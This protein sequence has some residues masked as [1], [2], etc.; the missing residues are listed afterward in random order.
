MFCCSVAAVSCFFISSFHLYVGYFCLVCDCHAGK[1]CQP[2][3]ASSHPRSDCRGGGVKGPNAKLCPRAPNC[4]VTPLAGSIPSAFR[5]DLYCVARGFKLYSLVLPVTQHSSFILCHQ[6]LYNLVFTEHRE[7]LS[8]A[9][10]SI[11]NLHK[12]FFAANHQSTN[13]DH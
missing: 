13:A 7:T 11:V 2:I 5:N 10:E 1:Q 3:I 12:V 6:K 9:R 4:S 8:T